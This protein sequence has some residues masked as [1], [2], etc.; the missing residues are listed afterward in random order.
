MAAEKEIGE[1]QGLYTVKIAGTVGGMSPEHAGLIAALALNPY[2]Q[3]RRMA[4]LEAKAAAAG[5]A[6]AQEPPT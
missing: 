6:P 2:D 4:E 1:L 3:Q 5:A